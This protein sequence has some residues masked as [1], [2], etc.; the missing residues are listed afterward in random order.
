MKKGMP[1]ISDRPG[2]C[3]DPGRKVPCPSKPART[4]V[5]YDGLSTPFSQNIP[6]NLPAPTSFL[7]IFEIF[8]RTMYSDTVRSTKDKTRTKARPLKPCTRTHN[9]QLTTHNSPLT[10]NE[11]K[12]L[13]QRMAPQALHTHSQLTTHAS[14][15]M[16]RILTA[17]LTISLLAAL[18][19]NAQHWPK[20]EL[21]AA[22]IATV[23]N[24]SIAIHRSFRS[25]TGF[26]LTRLHRQS[27]K[28]F[29]E[30]PKQD[31][32]SHGKT[33]WLRLHHT[34]LSIV[35]PKMSP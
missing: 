30:V 33:A 3:S 10:K 13:V 19:S 16:N 21:R 6:E 29:L 23:M 15:K 32:F 1:T 24:R 28:V 34:M 27:S 14:R 26:P 7:Q 2:C 12:T 35:F 5:Q 22:W 31:L 25:W 11:P 20:R 8:S 9:S 18:S 17:T 4:I